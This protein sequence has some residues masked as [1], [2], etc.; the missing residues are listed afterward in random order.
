MIVSTMKVSS[1]GKF[2]L[3]LNFVLVLHTTVGKFVDRWKIGKFALLLNFGLVL[4]TSVGR[5][6]R[7]Y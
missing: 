2:A 4:H 5:V 1:V 3:L 7:V 6:S